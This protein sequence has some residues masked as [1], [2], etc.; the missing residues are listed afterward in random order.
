MA[1]LNTDAMPQL[2]PMPVSTPPLIEPD[3]RFSRIRLSDQK[4][5]VRT[6][7]GPSLRAESD[8]PQYI[9]KVLI[10]EQEWTP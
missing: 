2:F 7:E 10:G 1:G 6:R 5:R 4:S 8:Q 3:G 9:V